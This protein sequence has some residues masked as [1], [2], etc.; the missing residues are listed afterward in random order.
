V[1]FIQLLALARDFF[2]IFANK[3]S[4]FYSIKIMFMNNFV[5]N[6]ARS[7]AVV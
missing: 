6:R 1:W 2:K 7:N 5:E 3:F 4:N